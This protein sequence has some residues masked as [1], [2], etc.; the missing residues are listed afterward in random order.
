MGRAESVWSRRELRM[1]VGVGIDVCDIRR[2]A[3]ALR[4]RPALAERLFTPGERGLGVASLAARFAAK[5][6]VAKA[7]GA[8]GNL[9]WQDA[10]VVKDAAGTP[11]LATRGTVAARARSMGI[12]SWHLS[13]SHDAGMASAL[14]VAEGV[15][16]PLLDDEP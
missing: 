13:L 14:V 9:S 12:V 8:P 10:E 4:R 2:F 1:I 6:A 7:L 3:E 16:A 15:G 5:E 11:R